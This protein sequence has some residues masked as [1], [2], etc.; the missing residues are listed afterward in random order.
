[1]RLQIDI[2]VTPS[3]PLSPEAISTGMPAPTSVLQVREVFPNAQQ[4][5][6]SRKQAFASYAPARY[7]INV[8][9]HVDVTPTLK[10]TRAFMMP[11]SASIRRI[12]RTRCASRTTFNGRR[13]QLR[14]ARPAG[15]QDALSAL[16]RYIAIRSKLSISTMLEMIRIVRDDGNAA[17]ISFIGLRVASSSTL[18][19]Q[20]SRQGSAARLLLTRPP[21]AP[22]MSRPAH[23]LAACPRDLLFTGPF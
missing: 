18:W 21:S 7:R 13:P 2:L 14:K 8:Q 15:S 11:I 6:H 19:L 4:E 1:M 23:I 17:R 5:K 9:R 16:V 3:F 10:L 12:V 20:I 22:L